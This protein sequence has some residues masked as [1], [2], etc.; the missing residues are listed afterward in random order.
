M[1]SRVVFLLLRSLGLSGNFSVT[2]LNHL[3]PAL[4]ALL[5]PTLLALA[6]VLHTHRD[7]KQNKGDGRKFGNTS[8]HALKHGWEWSFG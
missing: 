8:T 5:A 4:A 6:K 7:A 2:V 3:L 1:V